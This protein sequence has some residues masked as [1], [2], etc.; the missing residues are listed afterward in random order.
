M[1]LI[2]RCASNIVISLR[3]VFSACVRLKDKAK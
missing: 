1:T 3:I 2:K